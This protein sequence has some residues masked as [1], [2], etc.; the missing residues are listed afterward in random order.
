MMT[1]A[2]LIQRLRD[3]LAQG[4]TR[5]SKGMVESFIEQIEKGPAELSFEDANKVLRQVVRS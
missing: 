1:R 3:A 2:D 4:K 5:V